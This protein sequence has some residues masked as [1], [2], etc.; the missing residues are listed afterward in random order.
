MKKLGGRTIRN[1]DKRL[2]QLQNQPPN[3]GRCAGCGR[4]NPEFTEKFTVTR[5]G[6]NTEVVFKYCGQECAERVI[7]RETGSWIK[8]L[9]P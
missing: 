7:T 6:E 9:T 8:R 3:P 5:K 1:I 4:S 2:R